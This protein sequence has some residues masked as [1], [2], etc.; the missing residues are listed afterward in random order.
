[1]KFRQMFYCQKELID[2]LGDYVL[3]YCLKSDGKSGIALIE[4]EEKDAAK[5]FEVITA[6]R[7]NSDDSD[8]NEPVPVIGK[9]KKLYEINEN[10][11][12]QTDALCTTGFRFLNRQYRLYCY[13]EKTADKVK[14]K[15]EKAKRKNPDVRLVPQL[16]LSDYKKFIY[17]DSFG[18]NVSCRIKLSK[19]KNSPILFYFHGGGHNGNDNRLPLYEF[20]LARF[21]LIG[22]DITVVVPQRLNT[23]RDDD[24][25]FTS[26]KELL[27]YIADLAYADKNRI[28]VLGGSAGGRCTW[29]FVWRHPDYVAA[30]ISLCGECMQVSDMNA[31]KLVRIKDV[32]LWIAHDETDN[33]VSIKL[34]DFCVEELRKLGSPVRYTRYNKYGHMIARAFYF[35]EKW[36][37][38]MLDQSLLNR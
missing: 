17:V 5:L 27:D 2:A 22:K 35:K 34:D 6:A 20:N 9:N 30:A 18:N 37:D 21:G 23:Y 12:R 29:E 38:W 15:V 8:K 1:M 3:K 10:G 33:A 14:T 4:L 36:V 24:E 28:Y 31:D 19:N 26:S 7:K 13:G 32:P 11:I 25:V 16:T